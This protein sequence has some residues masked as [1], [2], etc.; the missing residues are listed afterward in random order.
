MLGEYFERASG[1]R[2]LL[3]LVASSKGQGRGAWWRRPGLAECL[4]AVGWLAGHSFCVRRVGTGAPP[5]V[6][7]DRRDLDRC[8]LRI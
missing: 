3:E 5:F 6:T 1:R 7:Y 8:V 2:A 4:E